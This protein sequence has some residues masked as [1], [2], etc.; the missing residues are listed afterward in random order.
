M[1]GR[2]GKDGRVANAGLRKYRFA[3]CIVG[4]LAG[5]VSAIG[6]TQPGAAPVKHLASP[7]Y[8]GE[9][10]KLADGTTIAYYVRPSRGQT[11]V[12]IPGSWGDYRVFDGLVAGL[13]K[14][15]QIV[16][17]ELRGH[18][19]S[20]PPTLNGSIEMFADDV[21]QVVKH[22]KLS[23]YL[24]GGHSIGG[25]IA[26]EIAGRNPDGLK[27]IVSMEGWT[28]AAVQQE[29]F[30]ASAKSPVNPD[31]KKDADAAAARVK[32]KLTKEQIDSF[33]TI[34]RRW[35]GSRILESTPLPVLE[36]WGDRGLPRPTRAQ[37][38]IPERSTIHLVWLT[39]ASHNYL[40]EHPGNVAIAINGFVTQ[41]GAKSP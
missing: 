11:L 22:L 8:S 23:N 4:A 26:I 12:L 33:E 28:K 35:D 41:V 29:A 1:C 13:S 30:G 9:S 2:L 16:V 3:V 32:G 7:V 15:L 14:D 24:A 31:L 27:G 19:R 40:L 25:M 34:W 37:L 21:L 38:H 6:A 17:V 18:G 10:L 20:G 5:V 36:I 39:G